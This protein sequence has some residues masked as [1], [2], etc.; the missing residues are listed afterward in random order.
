MAPNQ[1]ARIIF[2]VS[3]L[4]ASMAADAQMKELEYSLQQASIQKSANEHYKQR[5]KQLQIDE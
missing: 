5:R 3:P 2:P 1:A 4:S